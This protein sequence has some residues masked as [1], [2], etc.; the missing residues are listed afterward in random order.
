MAR[1]GF[2][3]GMEWKEGTLTQ[4]TVLS[5]LGNTCRIRYDETEVT[6][7]TRKGETRVLDHRLSVPD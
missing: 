7:E 5:K 3:I 4:V 6:F 2:E 1:G